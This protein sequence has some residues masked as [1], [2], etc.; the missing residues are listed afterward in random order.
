MSRKGHARTRYLRLVGTAVVAALAAQAALMAAA[1]A[2]SSTGTHGGGRWNPPSSPTAVKPVP[3]WYQKGA[4]AKLPARSSP[5]Y[6]APKVSLPPAGSV[7]VTL[8]RSPASPFVANSAGPRTPLAINTLV[9]AGTSPVYVGSDSPQ[10]PS[11]I[12]VSFAD[13][14]VVARSG[15][16]GLLLSVAR[17]DGSAAGGSVA[18]A[19][20]TGAL[21]GL[22]GG[23]F[24]HRLK[25]VRLPLCALS[26]PELASCRSQTPVRASW[27]A[28][29]GRLT[30][31]LAL[32]AAA[33]AAKPAAGSGGAV[34]LAATSAPA[35]SAG[36]YT[37]TSI[38]PSDPWSAGGSTGDF[39]YTYP[40]TVPPSLGGS[41]PNVTLAYSSS[42]VDGQT[43]ST[44]AQTSWIGDGW[45]YAPGSIER[46]Y[47][48]CGQD[49]ISGSGDTCWGYGGHEITAS[50]SGIAGQVVWDDAT[51]TWRM[52]GSAATVQLLTGAN[53]GAY[54]GEYWVVTSTDGTRYYYGAGHLPT[55]AGGTGSDPATDSAWTAPV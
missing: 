51:G 39:T 42:G 50:G 20:D 4:A 17:G 54:D 1:P 19:V 24:A 31:D 26:T 13:Q 18:V 28:A 5:T 43:V 27:D 46:T 22:Y 3:G 6:Q 41:A 2:R 49:G 35:G 38:K 52:G 33:E 10:S 25:L 32:P 53:N 40:V 12:R 9:Q 45:S 21:A 48:P 55:A 44:N 23:D 30:A 47:Q 14:A 34:V 7:D 29:T 36:T 37:A 11:A 16:H 8:G 15:V